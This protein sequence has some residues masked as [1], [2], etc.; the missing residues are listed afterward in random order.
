MLGHD[1]HSDDLVTFVQQMIPHHSNTVNMAKLLMK[2]APANVAA[3]EDL[4][5]MLWN[6]INVELRSPQHNF[7]TAVS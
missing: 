4:E 5:D 6:I 1:T 2:L 3:V 7:S